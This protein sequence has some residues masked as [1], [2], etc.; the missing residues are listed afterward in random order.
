MCLFFILKFDVLCTVGIVEASREHKM[1]FMHNIDD[2]ANFSNECGREN[3]FFI[4]LNHSSYV[5]CVT[6]L[7]IL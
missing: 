6:Y 5:L 4:N 2:I 1:Y 7:R 3:L